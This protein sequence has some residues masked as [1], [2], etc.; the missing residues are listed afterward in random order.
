[1]TGESGFKFGA[2]VLPTSDGLSA[3]R[4]FH[5]GKETFVGSITSLIPANELKHW[6]KW[7]GTIA[8]DRLERDSR[9]VIVRAPAKAPAVLDDDNQRLWGKMKMCWRTFLLSDPPFNAAGESWLLSG[10][11]AGAQA[12]A[13]LLGVRTASRVESIVRPMFATRSTFWELQADLRQQA[14]EQNG[15]S[16]E[17]WFQRW[18]EIDSS[19]PDP[20]PDIL[21]YAILAH[22]SARTRLELEFAIPELVRAAEGVIALPKRTGAS[23]FQK[24]ALQLAPQLHTDRFIST[25]V[26]ELL[27]DLYQARSDCVHGKVPFLTLRAQGEGG[28]ERAAQLAYVAHVLAHAALWIAL[29]FAHKEIFSSR[30]ALE[31]AW[32]NGTFPPR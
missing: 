22:G 15:D 7:I 20:C 32:S 16:N 4:I 5:D 6:P 29:R 18:M 13:P 21:A 19:L 10:E 12:G 14:I 25:D 26:E 27:L 17:L 1:M 2:L 31:L 9:L 8:W 28:E 3:S 23:L 11:A 24:R 30:Q